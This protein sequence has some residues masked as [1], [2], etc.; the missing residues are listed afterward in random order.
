MTCRQGPRGLD[1]FHGDQH[2]VLGTHVDVEVFPMA[3]RRYPPRSTVLT[4]I[5]VSDDALAFCLLSDDVDEL[6]VV[7]LCPLQG[8]GH[9]VLR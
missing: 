5:Q 4:G 8:D 2:V 7:R 3:A 6:D 9:V 1:A